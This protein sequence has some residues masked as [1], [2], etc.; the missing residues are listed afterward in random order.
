[1][2]TEEGIQDFR[3]WGEGGGGGCSVNSCTEI[4][5]IQMHLCDVFLS[6]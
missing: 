6:L 4:W 2:K 3:K 1:M 5:C